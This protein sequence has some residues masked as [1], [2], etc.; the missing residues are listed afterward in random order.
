MKANY[1]KNMMNSK[2]LCIY[3]LSSLLTVRGLCVRIDLSDIF[4]VK[5]TS[6]LHQCF[7]VFS[8]ETNYSIAIQIQIVFFYIPK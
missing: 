8:V 3:F 7:I 1:E 5:T 6:R 4:K 2:H